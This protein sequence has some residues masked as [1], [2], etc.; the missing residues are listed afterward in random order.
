MP[1]HLQ[2]FQLD[3]LTPDLFSKIVKKAITK[4]NTLP[5]AHGN[6]INFHMGD[7]ILVI[8]TALDPEKGLDFITGFDSHAKGC[9]VWDCEIVSEREQEI[10]D[11]TAKTLNIMRN[12][13]VLPLPLINGDILPTYE[14]GSVFKAQVAA[15]PETLD[16]KST[17]L[18]SSHR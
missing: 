9:C 14:K 15:Y 6:Y 5:A 16:R 7:M 2:S 8:R 17:R 3:F 11:V 4:G 18:N 10:I 12:G 13:E 1:D